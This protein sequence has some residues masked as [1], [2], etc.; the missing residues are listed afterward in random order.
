MA[1]KVVK[2]T[3]AAL[4]SVTFAIALAIVALPIV[5][6]SV[7]KE[8]TKTLDS[9]GKLVRDMTGLD[10][11]YSYISFSS[12]N[13]IVVR[14]LKL[15]TNDTSSNDTSGQ[16]QS[17]SATK[18]EV[19]SCGRV[20]IRLDLWA[21]ILGKKQSI[22][23]ELNATAL[24]LA[25]R[26]PTDMSI[27]N[28][29]KSYSTDQPK[30]PIPTLVANVDSVSILVSDAMGVQAHLTMPAFQVST[31]N[32]FFEVFLPS[33]D[34]MV[35]LSSLKSPVSG[36]LGLTLA[37]SNDYSSWNGNLRISAN[38][39]GYSLH[40]QRVGV[41]VRNGEIVVKGGEGGIGYE[42]RYEVKGGVIR[43]DVKVEGY[44]PD[45]MVE[46]KGGGIVKEMMGLAYTGEVKVSIGGGVVGY[47][48]TVGIKGGEGQVV[49]GVDVGGM[50]VE[51]TF[52][53]DGGGLGK[54]EVSGT[55]KEGIGVGYS[56]GVVYEGMK[57]GGAWWVSK[58]GEVVRGEVKGS[59]GEGYEVKVEDGSI[60]DIG[61]RGVAIGVK[62]KGS[63]YDV[64]VVGDVRSE[65]GWGSVRG[66]GSVTK[67]SWGVEGGVEVK[68]LGVM[69]I[70]KE[71]EALGYRVGDIGVT[72]MV[73]SGKGYV[74]G[75]GGKVSWSANGV[76]VR[77][78]VG[79]TEVRVRGDGVGNESG[80]EVKGVKVGIGKEEV[81][82]GGKGTYGDGTSFVGNIGYKGM[83]YG[84]KVEYRGGVVS[85]SGDYGLVGKV[86]GEGGGYRGEVVVKG[87]PLAAGKGVVYGSVDA[88]GS[89]VKGVW[90]VDVRG[91]DVRYEGEGN[92]P[93]VQVI[94]RVSATG[95]DLRSVAVR[96]QG[97][98]LTGALTVG[99]GKAGGGVTIGGNVT[100][101]GY[102]GEGTKYVIQGA[103]EGGKG[104]MSIGVGGYPLD[105]VG[106]K[107]YKATGYVSG[108]GDVDMKGIGAGDY[109]SLSTWVIEGS[110]G[111]DGPAYSLHEQR[112]GVTVRNGEIVVKGGE[113]G[114]G[115]EGRYEVKGGVIRGDVK[116]EG[117]RPDGM[118]EVKGGGIVKE[119]MGLAYTGEVKVSIGG[120]VVGYE[121]TVG[122]KGGEGQVVGG[123]DV[124]GM[125]VEGTFSGD[126]GG[127]GKV[128]VSGTTKEGIGVGYSGGVVYEGMKVGGAWW[129]SKGGEVVRGEVKGSG[130]E[131]YEVKVEDGS[132]GDIG[133]RGV[134]I[135]VK[136]KGSRY[137]VSVVGDV[138]S[139]GGWGSVRGE[140]SV[141]K[142]SWGVE[143]GVEVK[144][145]GVMGIVKEVEALGYRVGDI[146]VTGMV[147]SGK[148]Y[149][150]GGG[151]KV[152]WSANG[153]D[154][155]V[156]V[157]GTEVRVRGDGVGNESGYEVKG[158]KV[159]IG[160]EE[161]SIGGKGTY[162]DGTSFVGNIGYKGM[163][164]GVKV[165]YRGGV[166]SV[167]GDYG[168]VG[169]VWGEGG[170]YRGEVV[171][172]GL[173]LA[174]GKG[175]VYG[176][177]DAVGSVVKG[178]WGVDVRGSDVRYE[179]EGNYPEVQVIGRVSATGADLRSVA[180]RGQGYGLTGALTATYANLMNDP[181]IIV[182][183]SF[184][185]ADNAREKYDISAIYSKGLI[186][187]NV[188]LAGFQIERLMIK[189]L[190]GDLEGTVAF[191]GPF[192]LNK[193]DLTNLPPVNFDVRLEN[194]EYNAIPLNFSMSGEFQKGI[195]K[196]KNASLSYMN[197]KMEN[198]KSQFSLVDGTGTLGFDYRGVFGSDIL[199][200]SEDSK[201][202]IKEV[203]K[204]A[205]TGISTQSSSSTTTVA[206]MD[207]QNQSGKPTYE[208]EMS[209]TLQ[210]IKF[211]ET[212]IK[213]WAFSGTY[214]DDTL[215]IAGGNGD[216][217]LSYAKDGKITLF[218]SDSL[219]ISGNLKGTLSADGID[220]NIEAIK[221]DLSKLST[222][223][224]MGFMKITGG[225]LQGNMGIKGS[226]A[227]PEF[228]GSISLQKVSLESADI[229][230]GPIGP[231]NATLVAA[232]R[233]IQVSET[234]IPLQKGSVS[235][236]ASSSMDRWL[237]TNI[238]LNIAS[239]K[240]SLVNL[241]GKIAGIT[242]HN[243][244]ARLDVVASI[245]NDLVNLDG[246]IFLD[247]GEV[248]IDPQGFIAPPDQQ[249]Q[250]LSQP[251][252]FIRLRA[253]MSFG[254]QL[255]VF[256]P[257]KNVPIVS[258]FTDPSS[259]LLLQYDSAT[260][261][262]TLDGKIVLRTGYV[263]YYLRNFFLKS[264]E[265]DFAENTT[266]F[267]PLVSAIAELRESSSQ[268][269]I[270]ITLTAD[271]TPLENLHPRLTSVPFMSETQL[272]ALMSGGVLPTDTNNSPLDIR[273]AVISSSEFIPQLNIFK[274]FEQKVQKTLGLDIVYIRSTFLQR[275]LLD[276]TKP[277]T[278]PAPEDPLAY[279]LNQTELYFGKYL[280]DSAFL[281]ASLR[282]REDPLVSASRL[283]LD[284]EFGIEFNSPFGLISWS[285]TPALGTEGSFV[286]SQKLSLSW[287]FSY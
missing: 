279:Y 285:I 209:G 231:F 214:M 230:K 97:Y 68:D 177:V 275:W 44:R 50:G 76:D 118:V 218:L 123:V 249:S 261:D 122:I 13:E 144:D 124:G 155:R 102:L 184:S 182:K 207:S 266:K 90:G 20:Q 75:G 280:T 80:Y 8:V 223:L 169:K 93:E 258:G 166:V 137:D 210:N 130:G 111:V 147:V 65:G 94:G 274:S 263:M 33:L 41:T 53:G 127:L 119:M 240:N 2:I 46:V 49:G 188:N 9:V 222:F 110:V 260:Q 17:E 250:T 105:V 23:R 71:V 87:L 82:I 63:R 256:F 42:G 259:N 269:P 32:G 25:L 183:G 83:G 121:G 64:S 72:G 55:T 74:Q 19:F 190:K 186:I 77:V 92:Y 141:T 66:E 237:P 216:M 286:T 6:D 264:C 221:V 108:S 162:G 164:Y 235:I 78:D 62:D 247:N 39:G 187:G 255:Q 245:E 81:S 4:A 244:T 59:G 234:I 277:S 103:Y 98:G 37:S 189:N 267:N 43:G 197:H 132:I 212:L 45:G 149:V 205:V 138:R 219:P 173:P 89:V 27:F 153:V 206:A 79:G 220:M 287:Q 204:A 54:V 96:G 151:G 11:S 86:W 58:G 268:G 181:N 201:F 224:P 34:Y 262:F 140:G 179:G 21:A 116:V 152:S 84:V 61:V 28:K 229:V 165:E 126:G 226:L 195:A 30:G 168:L 246:S 163:G 252:T 114:I 273:S 48:G 47:E 31:L 10:T 16:T 208:G 248:Y 167:S 157:G 12:I 57:V 100:G 73:V 51:G 134:A 150:Q 7:Q 225:A 257:D 271:K 40:E 18:R 107:G 112:V 241:D 133:V 254:K 128:E 95:A 99:Y 67:G 185:N 104:R 14:D 192:Q 142:G 253:Q 35:K 243:A 199:Q 109:R 178:V 29:I 131:G 5:R 284:S 52:S 272:I 215:Q 196:V 69:G 26:T 101:S 242:V 203:A 191:N 180:V 233:S 85:V 24:S 158:V 154:V 113:G 159:G 238:K 232:G 125:G 15:Y 145:L 172:K 282:V 194:G 136:D 239:Q 139:E 200:L 129:V 270:V 106:V 211:H 156:D 276:V 236:S 56:G 174:A 148:G 193:L 36:N 176:S 88:V 175:V 227:D 171:V 117:Y 22:V 60:G 170:G 115:Y 143:G 3:I 278:Q 161:V 160:K 135:G 120:G 228:N 91:S 265:I 251:V 283:R 70:V 198:I 213:T 217:A 38:Y 1:Q 146:G 202:K 281:H